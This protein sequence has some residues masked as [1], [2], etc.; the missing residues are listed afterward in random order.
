MASRESA[1][2]LLRQAGAAFEVVE[3][4]PGSSP[5]EQAAAV[6]GAGAQP[7]R[8][9]FLRDKKKR[10]YIVT[11]L[12]DTEYNLKI[13]SGRLGLGSGNIGPAPDDALPSTLRVP[14]AAVSPLALAP[15]AGCAHT[16]LL[17]DARLRDSGRFALPA[18]D[19]ACS[20]V[21]D[22]PALEAFLKSIGRE[23]AWVDLGAN[24]KISPGSP[25][26]LK[27]LVDAVPPP[28]KAGDGDGDG[29]A[30]AAAPAAAAPAAGGGKPSAAAA[31]AAAASSSGSGA[32]AAAPK[33]AGKHGGGGGGHHHGGHHHHKKPPSDAARHLALTDV[34]ARAEELISL[35]SSAL[36]RAPPAEAAAAAAGGPQEGAYALGRL[37]ADVEVALSAFKNAA[38]TAGYSAGK[39]ELVAA[40]T[41]QWA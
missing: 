41:R 5:E 25:P 19:A 3:H 20:A 37:R 33:A 27:A 7:T 4:G 30:A 21:L 28:A 23:A 35:V 13:L 10:T 15:G 14:A 6:A 22:A 12:P 31:A 11:S 26:D 40:A 2:A 32:A 39:R 34:E 18:A 36:A 9:V 8:S 29:A 16:L 38:Y 17:L 24:V 1:L